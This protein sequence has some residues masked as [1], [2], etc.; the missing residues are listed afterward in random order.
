PRE[1]AAPAGARQLAP[2]AAVGVSVGTDIAEPHP[3]PRGTGGLRAELRRRV[4]LA[5]AATRG[6]DAG[7]WG[8]GR[9]G[10][11][12]SGRRTGL[13]V[14]LAGEAGSFSFRRGLA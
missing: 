8:A 10:A 12:H 6:D 4:H 11:R 13:A 9:L 1:G 5:R 14:G 3:A 7:W 2:G